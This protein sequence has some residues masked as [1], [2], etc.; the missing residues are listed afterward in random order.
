MLRADTNRPVE[1]IV[2]ETLLQ[3]PP[4]RMTRRLA[5]DTG[6]VVA[7]DLATSGLP[8]GAGPHQCPGRDHATAITIGILES[9]EGC[10]LTELNIDYEPSTALR[11]PA[12][13]VVVR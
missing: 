12:K 5:A 13:L 3:D 4:V 9:V 11:I 8:F 10:Q 2:A 1:T 7:V 6:T